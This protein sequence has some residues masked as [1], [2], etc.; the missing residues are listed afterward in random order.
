MEHVS[1]LVNAKSILYLSENEV[2]ELGVFDFKQLERNKGLSTQPLT[3]LLDAR[4][5]I[6][7]QA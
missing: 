3:I 5:E 7:N 1:E 6:F 4:E 2:I